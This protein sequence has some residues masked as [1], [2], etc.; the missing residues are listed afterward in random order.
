MRVRRSAKR[1]PRRRSEETGDREIVVAMDANVW[2]PIFCGDTG[3]GGVLTGGTLFART[4]IAL[5]LSGGSENT[6]FV[7]QCV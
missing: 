7:K 4:K 2:N 3:S 6:N 5:E 1:I